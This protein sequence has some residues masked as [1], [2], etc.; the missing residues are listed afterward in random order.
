MEETLEMSR[1]EIDRYAVLVQ[2][3]QKKL[4]QAQAA[5]ILDITDRHVRNLL[6]PDFGGL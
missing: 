2:V 4:T 3:Q 5:Q 6:S 1:K